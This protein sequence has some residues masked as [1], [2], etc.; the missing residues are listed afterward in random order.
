MDNSNK[1]N[2]QLSANNARS[3]QASKTTIL[4]KPE[5]LSW[6]QK[7]KAREDFM[8]QRETA[9]VKKEQELKTIDVDL[10]QK[11]ILLEEQKLEAKNG[12]PKLFEDRFS[13]FINQLEQREDSCASE[14]RLIE[15]EKEKLRQREFAVQKAEIQRDNGYADERAK[16]DDELYALRAK[17]EKEL[18]LKQANRLAEIEK[19]VFNKRKSKLDALEK[20]IAEKLNDHDAFLQKERDDLEQ[21]R[22]AFFIDKAEF[23]SGKKN[24]EYQKQLLQSSTDT[25]AE[26][27]S[28]LNEEIDKRV[29]N[30]KKSFEI[31]KEGFND[32][33]GL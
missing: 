7:L 8:S 17:Q 31:E 21:K 14:W 5:L 1:Q 26:K 15:A 28:N 12:F 22:K 30:R 16:F 13:V 3:G 18:E 32:E 4:D 29:E 11:R 2:T 23:E 27:E 6:H 33:I 19:E 24:M 9:V 10:N 20:E 25:L